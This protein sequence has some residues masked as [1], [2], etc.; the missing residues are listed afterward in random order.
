MEEAWQSV[1][2]IKNKRGKPHVLQQK[3][4][5]HTGETSVQGGSEEYTK[6]TTDHRM[7]PLSELTGR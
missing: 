6:P 3:I 2:I 7:V 5:I 4:E 1:G